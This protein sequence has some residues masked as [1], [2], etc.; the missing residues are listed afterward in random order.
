MY[1]SELRGAGL[2]LS[3]FPFLCFLT[4]VRGAQHPSWLGAIQVNWWAQC[5]LTGEWVKKRWYRTALVTQELI[6]VCIA[7]GTGL[8]LGWE[9][10]SCTWCG[11]KIFGTYIHNGM[12]L[13]REKWN[14][15]QHGCTWRALHESERSQTEK[16]KD[17]MILL[18]CGVW[19]I[20]LTGEYDRS[21]ADSQV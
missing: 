8:I 6:Q 2:L 17:C 16:D 21:E 14:S 1:I 5:S 20:Q 15:Q 19:K 18:I 11:Q 7:R 4:T 12:F 13:S 9:L 3:A 10:R